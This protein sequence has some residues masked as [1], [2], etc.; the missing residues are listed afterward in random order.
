M[1]TFKLLV[2]ATVALSALA[3]CQSLPQAGLIYSSTVNAGVGL[4]ISAGD[5]T[6]P[7][8][9]SIGFKT[10]DFA[11]V[12]VAVAESR[13]ND[14]AATQIE[15]LWASHSNSS[16]RSESCTSYKENI[17]K[18]K[19]P[20]A[21]L[22][23]REQESVAAACDIKRDAFSVYGQFNGEGQAKGSDKSA[24]L[25][26]GRV[27]ATGVAAQ[28]VSSAAQL[29]AVAACIAEV[30]KLFPTDG[31]PRKNALKQFCGIVT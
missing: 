24:G 23:D 25:M 1:K 4:K 2:V 11:Y 3:G 17:L 8:D 19:A 13:A 12:P 31:E 15:K 5:A 22:T 18:N 7:V 14:R 27:F 10:T 16:G 21:L 9:I 6:A 26:V 28:N 29:S 30:T 20:N